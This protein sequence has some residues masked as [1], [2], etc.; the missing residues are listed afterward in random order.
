MAARKGG[1]EAAVNRRLF[2]ARRA[3]A[4]AL[5]GEG[6]IIVQPGQLVEEGDPI[7]KGREDLFGPFEANVRNY[8]GRVEQA[9]A[10]PGEKRNR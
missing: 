4:T 7:L 6:P 2:V 8:P 5:K 10:A 1:T 3:F 9:T